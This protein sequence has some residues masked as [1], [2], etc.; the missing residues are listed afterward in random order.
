MSDN[1]VFDAIHPVLKGAMER[2]G[3]TGLTRIQEAVLQSDARG[4][5]LR[6][7]SQTG[8]GKTVALGLALAD[9]LL[10]RLAESND[11]PG[12]VVLV[13][14][15]T[16]ELATQVRGE[17]EWLFADVR[18]VSV[19]SSTGGTD[20][21]RD[22]YRL[23][24]R[25]AILV[26][27]PGRLNDHL[28]SGALDVS[29]VQH[30][31]LDEADQMLDMGFKEELDS[32]IEAL[33]AERRSHLVS[34]TFPRAVT[35]FADDFQP[36]A[37][38]LSGTRLGAANTDIEHVAHLVHARDRYGALINSL[39]LLDGDRCLVFVRR[40][41][42]ATELAELLAADGFSAMPFSGE[43]PQAQRTRTLDAFR[44]GLVNTLIATDVAARGID[45]AD[46]NSVVHYDIPNDADVYT[47]RSGRTGRAGQKGRSLLL[48]PPP[49][50]RRVDRLLQQ[51]KVEFTWQAVPSPKRIE[52]AVLKRTRRALRKQL[53]SDRVVSENELTFAAEMLAEHDPATLV[54]QLLEMSKPKLPREPFEIRELDVRDGRSGRNDRH[55]RPERR[56]DR[57]RVPRDQSAYTRF[58][59]NWGEQDG[60]TPSRILAHVC[61][62]GNIVGKDVGAV[63]IADHSATFDIAVDVAPAFEKD[64]GRR[65][66][67]D[68][69]IRIRPYQAAKNGA[70]HGAG[71]NGTPPNGGQGGAPNG[72]QGGTPNGGHPAKKKNG[73]SR[74]TAHKTRFDRPKVSDKKRHRDGERR[75]Y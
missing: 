63:E 7:S 59:I 45:V 64:A 28:R 26:G 50:K 37:L 65:D 46:I 14:T 21:S 61:R 66:S 58:F 27:T 2:R 42:D 48:V 74:P 55:E 44:H 73:W 60:A 30:V 17:L 1:D 34:A 49:A 6:L 23:K 68:P 4:A 3:F 24:R 35:R 25:D 38:H 11:R 10:E 40:R 70:N 29:G 12:P 22:R 19:A 20:V 62:R 53:E 31:V 75:R 71:P 67:R 9:E 15:P 69:H 57:P 18:E 5:N 47:H 16:R 56:T 51:A 33:P 8:S 13:I 43:L 36:D 39:L 54:A 72:G 32:I 52:K 41:C